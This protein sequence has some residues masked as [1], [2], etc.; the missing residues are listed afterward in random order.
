M[1]YILCPEVEL[2]GAVIVPILIIL[3]I[4]FVFRKYVGK[5]KYTY[6]YIYIYICI[7]INKTIYIV[8]GYN[9]ILITSIKWAQYFILYLDSL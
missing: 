1:V 6:E 2:C 3:C 7:Y 4:N 8:Y 9:I 5:E